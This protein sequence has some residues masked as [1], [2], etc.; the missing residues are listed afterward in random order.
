M[1]RPGWRDAIGGDFRLQRRRV[2]HDRDAEPLRGRPEPVHGPVRH[3][4]AIP[5]VMESEPHPQHARLVLPGFEHPPPFR[6]LD[7]NAPH[8]G[9]APGVF[10]SG[11]QG[12]V[13]A[14]A[15]PRRRHQDRTIDA[16][17][18]HHRTQL[19]VPDRGL[20]MGLAPRLP[21]PIRPGG[22]PDVY[23]GIRDDHGAF[24]VGYLPAATLGSPADAVKAAMAVAAS[25]GGV[26]RI[27]AA[28]KIRDR[29][30]RISASLPCG[31]R[32]IVQIQK[33]PSVRNRADDGFRK[34]STH[35]TGL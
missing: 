33:E 2:E 11:L 18:R 24:P 8:D 26:A 27:G 10:G 13:D 31:L 17:L 6:L 16:G 14:L 20:Q 25:H 30:P 15:L 34:S 29:P 7:G 5:L 12:I 28:A 32:V 4:R 35:P 21:R 23:A 3:P 22:A 9:K 19:F 1:R